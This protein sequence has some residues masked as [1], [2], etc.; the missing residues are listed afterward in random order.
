MQATC[1]NILQDGFRQSRAF[2]P[3]YLF[4]WVIPGFSCPIA[5]T[6]RLPNGPAFRTPPLLIRSTHSPART[7]V[8]GPALAWFNA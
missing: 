6:L 8:S 3:K 7:P 1:H 5:Q 2:N 4:P